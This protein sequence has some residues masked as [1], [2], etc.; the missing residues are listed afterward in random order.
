MGM[1]DLDA[2][3][4]GKQLN[5]SPRLVNWI[6][7]PTE[8]LLDPKLPDDALALEL[9]NKLAIP[10]G[11][12][13]EIMSSRPDREEHATI[14]WLMCRAFTDLLDNMGTGDD[15]EGWPPVPDNGGV[16]LRHV[17][18]WALVAAVP[19]VR[20]FHAGRGIPDDASWRALSTLGV[21]VKGSA[22]IFGR[23]G[24]LFGLWVP[25]LAFRGVHYPLGRLSFDIGGAPETRGQSVDLFV[26]VPAGD[27][28]NPAA[29]DQSFADALAF[30]HNHFPERAVSRFKCRSWLLD[31]QLAEYLP[32]TS[33]I[34]SFQ[35]RFELAAN[36][37]ADVADHE[38][39]EY[40]FNLS[41]TGKIGDTVLDKLPQNSQL[42][43]A[44]VQH[45]RSGRHW[46]ARSGWIEP[47]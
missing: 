4:V 23:S 5:L 13:A 27:R 37:V 15:Y 46:H 30:M 20:R 32:A 2:H 1:D 6:N 41:H 25:P 16:R 47:L 24:I 17:Y 43:R 35:R 26:H 19:F 21:A 36:T 38:L 22:S 44:Y 42:Q 12:W 39:L 34:L 45:L 40:V 31:P 33:N 11:A 29:C 28:L 9:F 10:R 14:Y 18:I 8:D 7:K 3:K